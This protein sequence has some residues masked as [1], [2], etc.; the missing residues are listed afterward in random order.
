MIQIV[1]LTLLW[2]HYWRCESLYH[3]PKRSWSWSTHRFQVLK[4]ISSRKCSSTSNIQLYFDSQYRV[5]TRSWW[6]ISS[7][8]WASFKYWVKWVHACSSLNLVKFV[9]FLVLAA[10]VGVVGNNMDPVN[11]VKQ[12]V[13][14]GKW[15]AQQ[16]AVHSELLWS[17]T[18][19]WW[20]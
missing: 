4:Q 12:D 6:W 2:F 3:Q 9:W 11:M 8:C 5:K 14:V 20:R 17:P 7:C 10:L 1:Q 16:F 18:R 15:P 13:T 19:W